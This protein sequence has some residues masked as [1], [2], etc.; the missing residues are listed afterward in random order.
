MSMFNPFDNMGGGGGGGSAVLTDKNIDTNGTY[1]ATDD[2]A[3]GYKKVVVDVP[4]T[5]VAGDE[6]KVVSNGALVDQTSVNITSN[7]VVDTTLNN[8]I[9]VNVPNTYVAGDEGKVVDNGAL[10][11]QGSTSVTENGTV[12]T[13]LYSSVVVNVPQV[14][15]NNALAPIFTN[16]VSIITG[17]IEEV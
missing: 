4:N 5:Y 17:N 9:T 10:V 6:G 12:D 1:N 3:D 11:T 8:S 13:T 16:N 15:P 7:G 14:S 2:G